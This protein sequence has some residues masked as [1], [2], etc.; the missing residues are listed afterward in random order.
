[1]S[2]VLLQRCCK[3]SPELGVQ[4]VYSHSHKASFQSLIRQSVLCMPSSVILLQP[5]CIRSPYEGF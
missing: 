3:S 2:G 4:P 5:A 1:M